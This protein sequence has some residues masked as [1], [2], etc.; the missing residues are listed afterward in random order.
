MKYRSN[1]GLSWVIAG[2]RGQN[3]LTAIGAGRRALCCSAATE[4]AKKGKPATRFGVVPHYL[5][6]EFRID[7]L[8]KIS[9]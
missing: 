1:T 2:S 5:C 6:I 3:E 4:K 9:A 8:Q 7:K